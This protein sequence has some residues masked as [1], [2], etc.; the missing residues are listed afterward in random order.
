MVVSTNEQDHHNCV[1]EYESAKELNFNYKLDSK[2]ILLDIKALMR[3]YYTVTFTATED[4][5]QLQFNNGQTFIVSAKE[6]L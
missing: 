3:E 5:L 6:V 2:S 1:T 4:A